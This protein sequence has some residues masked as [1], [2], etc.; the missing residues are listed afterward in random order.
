MRSDTKIVLTKHVFNIYIY[1][2]GYT[3]RQPGAL[4][5]LSHINFLKLFI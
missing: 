1:R 4:A 2:D 5:P 3:G